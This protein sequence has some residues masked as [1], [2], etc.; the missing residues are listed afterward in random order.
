MNDTPSSTC[1]LHKTSIKQ[2]LS[3]KYDEVRCIKQLYCKNVD[4]HHE[5]IALHAAEMDIPVKNYCWRLIKTLVE[6]LL[7]APLPWE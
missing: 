6:T 3:Q 4:C 5:K 2:S 1:K 7:A